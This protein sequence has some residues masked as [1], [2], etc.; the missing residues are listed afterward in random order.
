MV[1]IVIAACG[2]PKPPAAS[3]GTPAVTPQPAPRVEEVAEWA[4]TVTA[5]ETPIPARELPPAVVQG[6]ADL[7]HMPDAMAPLEL[8]Y[9]QP[10]ADGA[11]LVAFAAMRSARIGS[12]LDGITTYA[13]AS[14]A[15]GS[16]T[17]IATSKENWSGTPPEPRVLAARDVDGDG[18]LDLIVD[19]RG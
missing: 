16:F 1:L 5:A 3:G 4:G 9:A 12:Q 2:S 8:L 7:L 10:L 14:Y 6:L 17:L 15:D 11:G 18:A 13:L 19:G